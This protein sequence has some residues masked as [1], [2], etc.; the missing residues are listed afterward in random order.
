[1][2]NHKSAFI[3]ELVQSLDIIKQYGF[4]L[5]AGVAFAEFYPVLFPSLP[6]KKVLNWNLYGN[7]SNAT[8]FI[9]E[10]LREAAEK[11]T[12]YYILLC[13]IVNDKIV[14]IYSICRPRFYFTT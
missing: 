2:A 13:I 4:C 11:G 10:L 8:D 5:N 7:A 6:D 12:R 3:Y 1:M 9:I 14:F